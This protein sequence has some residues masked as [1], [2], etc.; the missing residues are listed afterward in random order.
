MNYNQKVRKTK[1]GVNILRLDINTNQKEP[2]LNA[3]NKGFEV[4]LPDT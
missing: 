2:T 3:A 4:A 1:L